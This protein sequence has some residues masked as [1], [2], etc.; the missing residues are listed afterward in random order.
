[1][2]NSLP[3]VQP[4]GSLTGF[5]PGIYTV[6]GSVVMMP[7]MRLTRNMVVVVADGDLTLV[8]SVRMDDEGTAALEA[9]GRVRNIVRIGMH[10]MDDAWYVRKYEARM[11]ALPGVTHAHDLV[12]SDEL[13]DTHLPFPGCRLFR[14]ELTQMPEAALLHEPAELLITCDSVQNWET[15]E[16]CSPAA[17]LAARTMGFMKPA[18]I[19]PPW[20]KRMTPSGGSLRPDFERLAALPFRHLIGGHG[21]PLRDHAPDRLQETIARVYG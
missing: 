11:W 2:S 14:F 8:N 17:A 10:G 19:G 9:L 4:H 21:S 13:S 20:R 6:R 7:L 5:A 1:M 3:G 16:G 18:Q 12:T 15:T